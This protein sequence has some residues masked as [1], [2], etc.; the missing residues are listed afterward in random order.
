MKEFLHWQPEQKS[1]QIRYFREMI[2]LCQRLMSEGHDC[3]L[4]LEAYKERLAKALV[5]GEVMVNEK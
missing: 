4:M 5:E 2:E 3:N 1:E